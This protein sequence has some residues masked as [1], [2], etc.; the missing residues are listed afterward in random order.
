[1]ILRLLPVLGVAALV[2]PG[3][4]AQAGP[5]TAQIDAAQAAVDARID[6]VAGAG[7]AGTESREARL[8]RQ[9]T[10][11]SVAQ[12]EGKLG[13]G[14]QAERALAALGRAREADRANDASGCEAALAEVRRAL[15]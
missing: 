9:P 10:P 4:S 5:C 3:A 2:I 7:R 11:G 14:A 13:E 15:Q 6:A 8:H 12:A 1:M